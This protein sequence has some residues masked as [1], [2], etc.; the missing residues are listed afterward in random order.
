M[1]PL[2][3]RAILWLA[4]A[5]AFTAPA[6][7]EPLKT[8][9]LT[10]VG[11]LMTHPAL[12]AMA[13]YADVFRGV[14][15]V[16]QGSDLA[17]ANL[18]F[19]VDSTRPSTG[20]PFFNAHRDYVAAAAAAGVNVFSTANNHAFDGGVEG[21]FETICALTSLDGPRRSFF[22]GTRGNPR[23]PFLPQGILVRGVRVGFIAATQFTNTGEGSRY[24]HVVDYQ[25]DKAAAEFQELVRETSPFFDVYIVSYHG[26]RE[27]KQE[28]SSARRAFFHR[29]VESGAT[30]VF[31]HHPH[32]L[33][34]HEVV[35]VQGRRRLIM[36]SMGN[37]ISGMVKGAGPPALD[38]P[39]ALLMDSIMLTVEVQVDAGASSVTAT[40]AIPIVNYRPETGGAVVLKMD[41]VVQGKTAATKA[42]RRYVEARRARIQDLLQAR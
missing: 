30:I 8:L 21:V 41:D 40:R 33:Q 26:D 39:E 32:V 4:F 7:A 1:R 16:L 12:A 31:G 20:Y 38:G 23:R 29:L 24:I 17:F 15:D 3:A 2:R 14:A 28:P 36:Y 22:S 27:Y 19:P 42:W 9:H 18:E 34:E 10:F 25:D 37:F 5:C 13:D 6:A 35:T 11:D